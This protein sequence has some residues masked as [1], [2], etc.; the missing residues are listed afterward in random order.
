MVS[1]RYEIVVLDEINVALH[2]KLLTV[3]EVLQ[4]I[5]QKPERVELVLTGQ[6]VPNAILERADYITVMQQDR[7]PYQ[8]GILARKGI[9]F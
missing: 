1:K 3:D 7:H 9:E 5:D 6:R 8:Q 4:T 2:F